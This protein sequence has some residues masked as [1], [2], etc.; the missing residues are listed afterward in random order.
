MEDIVVMAADDAMR[1]MQAG[2]APARL[3]VDGGLHFYGQHNVTPPFA[4]PS[5]ELVAHEIIIHDASQLTHW[6][7]VV[8]CK[9][10]FV[11]KLQIP[12]PSDALL[13]VTIPAYAPGDWRYTELSLRD[14]PLIS[15]LPELR[16]EALLATPIYRCAGLEVLP[17]GMDTAR[18]ELSHCPRLTS[19]PA[20]L[21]VQ[22]LEISDCPHLVQLPSALHVQRVLLADC[23]ELTALPG[24]V[25]VSEE[26]NL[27]GCVNLRHLPDTIDSTQFSVAGCGSLKTLPTRLRSQ[28][29]NLAG[30]TGLAGWDDP[31]ITTLRQ[32]SA[33]GCTALETL[34]PNL[35]QIDELDVRGC[36][37]LTALPPE[38]RITRWIDVAESGLRTLPASALGA[39][40]R[41]NGVNVT[42]QIAFHPEPLSARQALSAENAELRRVMVERIGSERF[43]A[44]ANP[45]QLDTDVD[46]GGMRRLLRVDIPDDEPWVALEVRDPS[47]GRTYLLRVPPEI[48][49]CRRA[50]AWVAG[51]DNPDDY[52]PILET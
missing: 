1:A 50:A 38:L 6:P 14:C 10:L 8:R 44:E 52:Q 2:N 22:V 13:E 12:F 47:T 29:I 32:L 48:D 17:A 16:G 33:Q 46:R 35:H 40:V 39:Q 49:T 19:L 3:H 51:F 20:D 36:G 5:D 25:A 31:D 24:D 7:H 11:W 28:Y 26:L 43:V 42:G 27:R 34:P 15:R 4:L 21:R 18:L 9:Q 23:K 30:C 45:Q 41:W 37:Q